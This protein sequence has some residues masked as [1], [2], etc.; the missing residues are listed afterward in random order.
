MHGPG[1]ARAHVVH[2]AQPGPDRSP[3]TPGLGAGALLSWRAMRPLAADRDVH[4]WRARTDLAWANQES[5]RAILSADE[6]ARAQHFVRAA[7][8]Q[9]FI[10]TRAILRRLLGS[11]L[12]I[13]PCALRFEYGR[14][15][16]PSLTGAVEGALCFSV[17][18]SADAALVAVARGRRIGV[19]LEL[20]RNPAP[21]DV[22]R[23]FFAPDELRAL[24]SLPS[25]EQTTAFYRC[26]TRK[27]AY[28]KAKGVGLSAPLDTFAV[29]HS[30]AAS[31]ALS[32]SQLDP[33]GVWRWAFL[34]LPSCGGFA[35][36]VVVETTSP[37]EEV[38]C[39]VQDW[40]LPSAS[41]ALV[42]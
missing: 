2:R 35:A 11:Y 5:D 32:W 29:T 4:V 22:A 28:L 14:Y 6:L 7:D 23:Q 3:L 24:L 17:A 13:K 31:R 9:R 33:E 18:H 10:A 38:R 30:P 15:G 20:I 36:S 27:E 16:K 34:D 39:D 1:V 40:R 19:D 8:A 21:L 37:R 41:L 12:G 26:W 25:A 42:A